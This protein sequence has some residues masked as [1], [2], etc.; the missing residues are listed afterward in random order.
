MVSN[1]AAMADGTA[2]GE[3]KPADFGFL[4]FDEFLHH[5]ARTQGERTL[6]GMGDRVTSYGEADV[7]TRQM[8]A[9][10]QDNGV[11][12]GDRIA[13][14]GKNSD[15]YFLLLFAAA[16]I[17]AVMAP[18][19]WR[20]ANPEIAY[21]LQDTGA[22]ILFAEPDFIETAGAVTGKMD[23]APRVLEVEAAFRSAR[24]HRP[25]ALYVGDHGQSQG[26]R[27]FQSQPLRAAPAKLR[28]GAALAAI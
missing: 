8:I 22:K 2:H 11:A 16:R 19:G 4:T 10:F 17:G 13:W 21:I 20:L 27:T 9:L 28:R 12:R 7:L 25:A 5:W 23:N 6:I 24:R 18:I 15:L 3:D 26:R 1:D 14:L